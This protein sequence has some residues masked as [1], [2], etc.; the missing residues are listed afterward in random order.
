MT[1]VARSESELA[2][3]ADEASSLG[4]VAAI[5]IADV[6]DEDSVE[7]MVEQASLAAR[8]DVLVNAAGINVPQPTATMPIESWDTI[9]ATNLRGTLLTCRAVGRRLLDLGAPGRLISLSSQMGS[10]GDPGRAAYCASKH[11]VDGLT[12]ALAVEWGPPRY[13]RQ[14]SRAHVH[15]NAVD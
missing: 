14:L 10:V 1:L 2:K 12:K 13:H 7:G 3:V 11:G 4:G 8:I 9:H 6:T 5:I 15:P